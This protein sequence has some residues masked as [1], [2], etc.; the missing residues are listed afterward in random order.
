MAVKYCTK[1]KQEKPICH[2]RKSK[3]GHRADCQECERARKKAYRARP[4]IKAAIA[5]YNRNYRGPVE[6]V[7][8]E[9][10]HCSNCGFIRIAE[11]FS[12]NQRT[13][14][15]LASW[16]KICLAEKARNHRT[17]PEVKEAKRIYDSSPKVV[18]KRRLYQN[19]QAYRDYQNSYGKTEKAREG[20]RA[21]K[22]KRR[23]K[24]ADL[25][26]TLTVAEW[27]EILQENGNRCIYCKRGFSETVIV[28]QDHKL[29]VAKGGGHTRE[30]VVPACLHCNCSKKDG[31]LP[32]TNPDGT[33]YRENWLLTKGE[34]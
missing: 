5:E 16:C 22:A 9:Q 2:F 12:P 28:T 24:I 13:R 7:S 3:Y 27:L 32:I 11:E 34:V 30:N 10:K 21:K 31:A 18:A 26:C 19:S 33:P 23:A 15:G 17:N 14:D 8:I 20:K 1:C 29:A 6:R 25:V 4:E